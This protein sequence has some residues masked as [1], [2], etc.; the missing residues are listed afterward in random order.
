MRDKLSPIAMP[1][2]FNDPDLLR[3]YEEGPGPHWGKRMIDEDVE[4]AEYEFSGLVPEEE[5]RSDFKDLDDEDLEKAACAL[6]N[7]ESYKTNNALLR[8][9]NHIED[10]IEALER[11]QARSEASERF[12]AIYPSLTQSLL[13]Q[14][15]GLPHGPPH[16]VL[17]SWYPGQYVP[18]LGRV[19]DG[20]SGDVTVGP[21]PP[22]GPEQPHP[23]VA[24][25]AEKAKRAERK[26]MREAAFREAAALEAAASS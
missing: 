2:L 13:N 21:L 8:D 7:L 10:S 17:G 1:L 11:V 5:L 18:E 25:A 9:M 24:A 15:Q 20:I 3:V 26:A 22:P 19:V 12:H 16:S 4:G 23:S 6:D 14:M